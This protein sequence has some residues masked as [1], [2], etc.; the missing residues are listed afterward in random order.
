M[1]ETDALLDAL[2]NAAVDGDTEAATFLVMF[3]A[4]VVG[5]I[6]PEPVGLGDPDAN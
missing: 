1:D 4:W 3:V 5:R 6:A 2:W